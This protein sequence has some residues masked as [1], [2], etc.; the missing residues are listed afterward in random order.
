MTERRIL[1]S[2]TSSGNDFQNLQA[3]DARATGAASRI[4]VDVVPASGYAIE[5]IHQIFQAIHAPMELRPAAVVVEALSE[6]G[7]ERLARNALRAGI[8][9]ISLNRRSLWL[10]DLRREFPDLPVASVS[11]D[12]AAV[13]RLQARQARRL[14]P[15]GG[16]AFCILGPSEHAATLERRSGMLEVLQG[17]GIEVDYAEGQWT[18]ESGARLMRSR[19]RLRSGPDLGFE[20]L[21]CQNDDMA[22]GA[23]EALMELAGDPQR[24]HWAS[25]PCLGVD[26]LSNGGRAMV[27][28]GELAGTV[29][30]PPNT[31]PAI[32]ML[33]RWLRTGEPVIPEVLLAPR[34]YPALPED[35]H[36]APAQAWPP[37]VQPG[38]PS[39]AM[40]PVQPSSLRPFSEV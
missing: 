35:A 31:G 19:A 24:G 39:K 11:T 23:R 30:N 6:D 40:F 29:V 2:L 22:V 34:P 25:V 5:Q 18:R 16:A 13:G 17:S 28:R 8:G 12:Q 4:V 36:A 27:D 15:G 21:V 38:K 14:L 26:G 10:D 20:L 9:W 1:V 33:A 7:L 32:T 37:W 3:I